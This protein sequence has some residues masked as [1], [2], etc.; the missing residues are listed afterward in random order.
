MIVRGPAATKL[1]LNIKSYFLINLFYM[2]H[3]E[4]ESIRI[5]LDRSVRFESGI[6][7]EKE[8]I[9]IQRKKKVLMKFSSGNLYIFVGNV[10]HPLNIDASQV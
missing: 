4:I 3:F 10:F 8:M 7:Y 5:R 6:K 9:V 1:N 2:V